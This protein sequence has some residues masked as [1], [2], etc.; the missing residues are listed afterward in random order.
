M[1]IP[2]LYTRFLQ[3]DIIWFP[4]DESGR[5]VR[6]VFFMAVFLSCCYSFWADVRPFVQ[7]ERYIGHA[8][9]AEVASVGR[10]IAEGNGPVTDCVWLLHNGGR[11]SNS[12]QQPIGYWSLY[13][14]GLLAIPFEIFGANRITLLAVAS[15]TK[16]VS[17]LIAGSLVTTFTKNRVAGLCCLLS[18]LFLPYM[19]DR[20]NGYSDIWLATSILMCVTA[21]TWAVAKQSRLLWFVAGAAGG[22]AIGIKPSGLLV[23]GLYFWLLVIPWREQV[24]WR[25][26]LAFGAYTTLGCLLTTAP[27]MIHNY[28]TAGTL[29]LPDSKLVQA[30]AA[31]QHMHDDVDHNRAFFDPTSPTVVLNWQSRIRIYQENIQS[32]TRKFFKVHRVALLAFLFPATCYLYLKSDS[33]V[34]SGYR[35][36]TSPASVF[37]FLTGLLVVAGILLVAAIHYESRYWAFLIAPCVVVGFNLISQKAKYLLPLIL[38]G[39]IC[40][41]A[42]PIFKTHPCTMISSHSCELEVYRTTATLLPANSVVLTSTPWEFSFHTRLRSVVL[43]PTDNAQTIRSVAKR[44]GAQYVVIVC[45]KHRH[46][47]FQPLVDGTFP[48]Y[49]KPVLHTDDLVIGEFTETLQQ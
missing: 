8:D 17:A 14:A 25:Q 37:T 15:T 30:A 40:L 29:H 31:S 7:G 9:Q 42:T 35:L 41:A 49:L 10:N 19:R 27:L 47:S 34:F 44:Y 3:T 5:L 32:F 6:I 39:T 24:N 13:V 26:K 2:E 46:P 48:S 36:T 16:M 23:L 12:A 22:F 1:R 45:G 33:Q 21:L 18:V 20:V 38:A 43:P 28:Q 11:L 4:K